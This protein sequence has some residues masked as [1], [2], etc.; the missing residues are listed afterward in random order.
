MAARSLYRPVAQ[1][2]DYYA[3]GWIET[4]AGANFETRPILSNL[5]TQF[6]ILKPLKNATVGQS[7]DF[8]PGC[9][10]QPSTCNTKFSNLVNFGG[11]PFVPQQNP[12]HKAMDRQSDARKK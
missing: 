1:G 10:G 5:G 12:T 3:G 9:D 2:N 11:H 4:G 7:I 6:E 8:Y